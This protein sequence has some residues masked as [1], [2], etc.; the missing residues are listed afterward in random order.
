[1]PHPVLRTPMPY[2]GIDV[3]PP[4]VSAP[5]LSKRIKRS[6]SLLF[7]WARDQQIP[8]RCDGTGQLMVRSFDL[9]R[10]EYTKSTGT[11]AT[12]NSKEIDYGSVYDHHYILT[13]GGWPRISFSQDGSS[14]PYPIEV[15]I[16]L[17]TMTF[18]DDAGYQSTVVDSSFR[19]ISIL[20]D[21]A[22]QTIA[23]RYIAFKYPPA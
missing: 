14:T 5:T 16:T 19:Y 11:V 17:G 6:F 4:P 21:S 7:G 18:E 2:G 10:A 15:P 20:N 8:L 12:S 13:K 3:D 22:T 9:S 1:M 23:F